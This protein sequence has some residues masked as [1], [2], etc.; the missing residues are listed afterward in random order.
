MNTLPS[1]AYTVSA[2]IRQA[3]V[4]SSPPLEAIAVAPVFMSRKQPVPY[5]FLAIPGSKQA[6]PKSAACWSPATPAIGT[7]D[8][9]Q[10]RSAVSPKSPADGRTVGSRGAGTPSSAS[11]VSSQ[12]SLRMSRRSVR[13]ALEGSVAWTRP[14]VRFH[15]SHVSTVPNASSPRRARSRAPDTASSSQRIFVPEK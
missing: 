2:P 3:T 5:V 7:P 1:R 8:G 14:P 6:W 12:A 11:I 4:A 9:S 13:D 15:R 10:P